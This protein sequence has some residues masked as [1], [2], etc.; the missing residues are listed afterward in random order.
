MGR[1]IPLRLEDAM[2]DQLDRLVAAGVF[3]NRNDGI[4]AGVREA[5]KRFAGN[6][7]AARNAL[8]RVIANYLIISQQGKIEAIALFGSVAAG[9]DVPGS[10]IDILV[11]TNGPTSYD[12]ELARVREVG[13]LTQ[14]IDEQVSLHHESSV[15]FASGLEHGFEFETG[16][17][18][19]GILLAG[20]L[21]SRAGGADARG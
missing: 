19:R 10:D 1:I 9:R 5:L 18:A 17:V 6:T 15:D 20:S 16:I 8:A 12:V 11:I 21:T 7:T 14:G 4:R 2:A 13:L 3:L